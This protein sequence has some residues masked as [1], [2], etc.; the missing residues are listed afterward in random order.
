MSR[1]AAVATRSLAPEQAEEDAQ[2]LHRAV[3]QLDLSQKPP[4][5][6]DYP[7]ITPEKAQQIITEAR[8]A[9]GFRNRPLSL[10]QVRRWKN[11]Y[12]TDRFVHFF[13]GG[14]LCY[15]EQGVLI[16]GHHRLNGLAGSPEGTKAGFVVFKNVPRW[17]FRFFDTN[18]AR[19]V[20][21]VFAIGAR[22][23]GPQTPSAM[24]LAMRYEE[25]IVGR[26]S[27]NG[28]RHWNTEKDEND[29]ID[30]FYERRSELQDWYSA[31]EKIYRHG[32]LL[33]PAG[34]VFR[35]YQSLAWPDG[36]DEIGDF[37]EQL[38]KGSTLPATHPV[39]KLTQWTNSA[40]LDRAQVF[41]K[42]EVHLHLL[43]QTFRQVQ[44]N[45]RIEVMQ[46]AYGMPMAMPYHPKGHEV[47]IKNVRAALDEIDAHVAEMQR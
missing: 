39:R 14:P 33:V 41:A 47:A 31:A 29:D 12:R 30:S 45:S 9:E 34:M 1:S 23:F 32:R 17:M 7:W 37:T 5:K 10:A 43:F 25:F 20:K 8:Q 18:K 38:L 16:N 2:P 35:F 42:R 6:P 15:D 3:Q 11:L 13:P 21:D 26:R 19:S 22:S 36:D 46:W 40:Y 28:W 24:K 4:F 27:A 44:N